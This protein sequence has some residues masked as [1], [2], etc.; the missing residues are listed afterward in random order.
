A[1]SGR[2]A[3]IFNLGCGPAREVQEFLA[4]HDVADQAQFRLLDFNEET[5]NHAGT[6]LQELKRRNNRRTPVKLVR[7]SV[8]FFLKEAGKPTAGQESYD[9][10]YCS[11]LYDYLSD[12]VCKT[13]NGYLYDLLRPGGALIVT[14]FDPTNPI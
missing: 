7:Q 10:I 2:T 4:N 8:H 11:G 6:R 3:N 12:R 1:T 14:N 9:L 13:L 5:L